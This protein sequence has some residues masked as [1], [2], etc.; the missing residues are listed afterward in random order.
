MKYEREYLLKADLREVIF[1]WV[2]DMAIDNV[3]RYDKERLVDMIFY[4]LLHAGDL[5][6]ER[7]TYRLKGLPFGEKWLVDITGLNDE[8]VM[9]KIK[10]AMEDIKKQEEDKVIGLTP[11]TLRMKL[12]CLKMKVDADS[13]FKGKRI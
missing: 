8:E 11:K 3:D 13:P 9:Q 1:D 12:N 10:K 4:R 2:E 5:K 6:D 7:P